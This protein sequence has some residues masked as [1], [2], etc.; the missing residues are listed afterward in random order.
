MLDSKQK[1]V[2]RKLSH[3]Q[4]VVKFVVGKNTVDK[5]VLDTLEKGITKHELIK[6]GF[7]KSALNNADLE[8][9]ILDISGSLH[10]D[11][12]QQIGHTV[13]LYRKN[14]KIVNGIKL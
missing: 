2:L 12:V 5:D 6:I 13:L 11:V 8:Q 14:P 1:I 3:T 4:S 9:L 7:L 10:A